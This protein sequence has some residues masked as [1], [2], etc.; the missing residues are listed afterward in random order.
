MTGH[1]GPYLSC[2]RG[3]WT[4]TATAA[5]VS[6]VDGAVFLPKPSAAPASAPG[7]DFSGAGAGVT[8][9]GAR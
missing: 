1:S 8:P 7:P 9:G 2:T 4:T 6:A 3:V 5:C